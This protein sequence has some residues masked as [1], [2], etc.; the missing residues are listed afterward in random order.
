MP[1]YKNIHGTSHIHY[2]QFQMHI[3][4]KKRRR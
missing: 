2:P 1:D 3:I 4:A